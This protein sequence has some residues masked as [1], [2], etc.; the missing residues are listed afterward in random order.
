M[1]TSQVIFI[2]RMMRRAFAFRNP[3]MASA[4]AFAHAQFVAKGNRG[5]RLMHV[6]ARAHRS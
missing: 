1:A 6:V 4:G 3:P 5:C 2:D